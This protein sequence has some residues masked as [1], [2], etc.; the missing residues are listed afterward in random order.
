MTTNLVEAVGDN[1]GNNKNTTTVFYNWC[2]WARSV[3]IETP[4]DRHDEDR[5]QCPRGPNNEDDNDHNKGGSSVSKS[6]IGTA[7]VL[8]LDTC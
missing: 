3:P 5:Y 2:H 4:R 8:L 1:D 6:A 7:R